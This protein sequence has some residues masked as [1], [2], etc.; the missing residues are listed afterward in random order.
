MADASLEY[1]VAIP[2]TDGHAEYF[3][4]TPDLE[5]SARAVIKQEPEQERQNGDSR[6]GRLRTSCHG[7]KLII[8]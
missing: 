2:Q 6:L 3:D 7:S 1:I 8:S 5:D 4:V